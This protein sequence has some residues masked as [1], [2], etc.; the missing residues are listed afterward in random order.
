VDT[1]GEAVDVIEIDPVR[2][3]RAIRIGVGFSLASLLLLAVGGASTGGSGSGPLETWV[4]FSC[5]AFGLLIFAPSIVLSYQRFLRNEPQLTIRTDGIV[6]NGSRLRV[7]FIPWSEIETMSVAGSRQQYVALTLR[8]PEE[9]LPRLGVLKRTLLF[10]DRSI[11]KADVIL[12]TG[13]LPY[14]SQEVV[15]LLKVRAEQYGGHPR[16][17]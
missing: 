16:L 1:E 8:H 5:G 3:R 10:L 4:L 7:A 14:S 17:A 6:D 13:V 2:G 11:V 12:P 9:V 15:D